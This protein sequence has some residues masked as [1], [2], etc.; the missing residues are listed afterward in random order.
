MEYKWFYIMLAIL[1]IGFFSVMGVGAYGDSQ[2]KIAHERTLMMTQCYDA[3][4]SN[5][6]I[7]CDVK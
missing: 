7:K 1:G 4:R 6:N 2:A 3:A 5:P